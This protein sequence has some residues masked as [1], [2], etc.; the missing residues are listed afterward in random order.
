MLIIALL[1]A[2]FIKACDTE[3]EVCYKHECPYIKDHVCC[4]ECSIGSI[5][6]SACK[7]HPTTCEVENKQEDEENGKEINS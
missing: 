7:M 4:W 6:Q 5:C 3:Q 2:K 1:T